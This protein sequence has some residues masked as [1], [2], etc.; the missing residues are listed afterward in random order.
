M[1]RFFHLCKKEYGVVAVFL[2]MLAGGTLYSFHFSSWLHFELDQSYDTLVVERALEQGPGS[3]PLLGPSIGSGQ[4]LR[5]PPA[6]Y[7][8]EYVS[9]K[10]FGDT[11]VGH[12]SFVPIF[13]VLS[14]LA[15]Y[16]LFRRFFRRPIAI[17]LMTLWTLSLYI[18]LY[19][20]FSWNPNILPLLL[21][22]SFYA[23]LRS[24]SLDEKR[25]GY[26]FL[27]FALVFSLTTQLHVN[28]F[29]VLPPVVLVFLLIV[30][31]K[32]SWRIWLSAIGIVGILYSPLLLNDI[33]GGGN[34]AV[35]QERFSHG[36][37]RWNAVP[38]AMQV[39]Q[40][41]ASNYLLIVSGEDHI[42]GPKLTGIGFDARA[43][44][45]W[46]L[47]ALIGLG[48]LSV[49]LVLRLFRETDRERRHMLWLMSLWFVISTLYFFALRLD[50]FNIYPRFFLAVIPIPFFLIGLF[51]EE[52][53][54][55]WKYGWT[56]A[57]MTVM[58]LA[59]GN[60]RSLRIYF[61]QMSR[62]G[63]EPIRVQ[64]EDV[65]PNTARVTLA[66]QEAIVGYIEEKYRSNGLP[67]Y[68][69]AGHEFT[70]V[71]WYHLE[72]RGISFHEGIKKDQ[73]Y[74]EGNYFFILYADSDMRD[75][76]DR[77]SVEERRD[78]GALVVYS[79]VPHPEAVTALRQDPASIKPTLQALQV[80][81]FYTWQQL[82]SRED[83]KNDDAKIEEEIRV[84][85]QDTADSALPPS[86]DEEMSVD[87][88]NKS[89]DDIP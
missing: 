34:A 49:L 63:E 16:L 86:G 57:V 56:I 26:W 17:L 14:I 29:F 13:A 84:E 81:K 31:P 47:G 55:Y 3:L 27:M 11:P 10:V 62:V 66:Q 68:L 64:T 12:A 30:R 61:D 5:L 44:Y 80:S 6:Y 54:R 24:V 15:A 58:I 43:Q 60:I 18:V 52:C 89:L 73:L 36:V 59:H 21:P 45:W 20:R 4:A 88:E 38:K 65:F 69:N 39:L 32:F 22:F 76:L 70:P 67:V 23:L 50:G 2:A 82:F 74:A 9:A 87:Q 77:F 71:F 85:E 8:L 48:A 72:K 35:F 19:A 25:N 37:K 75:A 46:R 28:T 7:Y 41:T 53:F 51:L 78:F 33:H 1:I 79:V 42:N 40:Y 83:G